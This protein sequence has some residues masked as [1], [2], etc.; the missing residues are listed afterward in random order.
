MIQ[1]TPSSHESGDV[2][3]DVGHIGR[4]P[5]EEGD[6]SDLEGGGAKGEIQVAAPPTPQVQPPA[7]PRRSTSKSSWF[8]QD[9]DAGWDSFMDVSGG[10]DSF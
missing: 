9:D 6:E 10:E 2:D 1:K 8:S 3:S 5:D 4:E 7:P